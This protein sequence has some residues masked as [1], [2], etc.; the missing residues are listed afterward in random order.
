MEILYVVT[1][2]AGVALWRYYRNRLNK[3]ESEFIDYQIVTGEQFS[4][5]IKDIIKLQGTKKKKKQ[6]NK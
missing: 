6:K 2:I 1:L 5:L 4:I 3:L